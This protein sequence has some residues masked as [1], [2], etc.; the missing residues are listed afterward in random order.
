MQPIGWAVHESSRR[1]GL[2]PGYTRRSAADGGIAGFGGLV[3]LGVGGRTLRHGQCSMRAESKLIR[4]IL[5]LMP[6]FD[7]CGKNMTPADE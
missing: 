1:G 5:V 7:G 6:R 3:L 2:V 4:G